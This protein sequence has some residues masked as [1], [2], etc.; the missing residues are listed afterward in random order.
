MLANLDFSFFFFVEK[1]K[2]KPSL[3]LSL[4]ISYARNL[5]LPLL[6]IDVDNPPPTWGDNLHYTPRERCHCPIHLHHCSHLQVRFVTPRLP[7]FVRVHRRLTHTVGLTVGLNVIRE[8]VAVLKKIGTSTS[9]LFLVLLQ[10]IGAT[11][12]CRR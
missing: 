3:P 7:Q 4:E 6:H 10:I 5:T 11:R 2:K 8:V 9:Y 1:K 12:S